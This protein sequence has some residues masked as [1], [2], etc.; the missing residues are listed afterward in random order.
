MINIVVSYKGFLQIKMLRKATVDSAGHCEYSR[1][2][3]P[4]RVKRDQEFPFFFFSA[5]E[6]EKKHLEK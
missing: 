5:M 3:V 2:Q 4:L 1:L 6:K